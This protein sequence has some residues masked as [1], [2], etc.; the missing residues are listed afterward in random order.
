MSNLL[1]KVSLKSIGSHLERHWTEKSSYYRKLLK[2]QQF[3][4]GKEFGKDS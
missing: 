4:R 1:E 2:T 3:A